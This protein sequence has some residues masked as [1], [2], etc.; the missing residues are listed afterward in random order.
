MSR[1]VLRQRA[2]RFLVAGVPITLCD[3]GAFKALILTGLDPSW[4]RVASFGV[5][6]ALAF[7][8]HRWWTFGS[9]SPWLR[10]LGA[11][12]AARVL[13]FLLAALVFAALQTGLDVDP[14]LAFLL[15]VPVQPIG[16]FLAGHFL[17]FRSSHDGTP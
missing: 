13:F 17:V 4:A 15:Q 10:D 3:Y 9:T 11:Y 12:F 6:F 14:D 2:L 8:L 5:A 16:N 7:M 1:Q